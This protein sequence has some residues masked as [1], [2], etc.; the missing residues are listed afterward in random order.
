MNDLQLYFGGFRIDETIGNIEEIQPSIAD[1]AIFVIG[2][3]TRSYE[4]LDKKLVS[5]ERCIL[6]SFEGDD[7]DQSVIDEF[8]YSAK[9]LFNTVILKRLCST[10]DTEKLMT[11]TEDFASEVSKIEPL[12]CVVDY[13]SMP[14]LVTQT[15]F[16]RFMIDGCC[17]RVMWLYLTGLYDQT[18]ASKADFHQGA[19]KFFT[20]RGADGAGGISTEKIGVLALGSDRALIHSFLLENS[21]DYTF[22]LSASTD[23]SPQLMQ[24]INEQKIWL[25]SEHGV[26]PDEFVECE[27]STVIGTLKVLDGILSDYDVESGAAIDIFCSGPKSHAIAASALVS[28]RRN[29]R[30]VGRVPENYLRFDVPPSGQISI[31]TVSD[32]TNPLIAK[33]LL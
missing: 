25:Q 31:T 8:E 26:S 4:A 5:G 6:L 22:F 14:K 13:S 9:K 7:I 33:V 21:Y 20:I 2:W 24:R 11:A 19:R 30:L 23:Y 29:I 17:P 28:S 1:V 18:P 16:R 3:E 32:F 15:L 10:T 12:V 27:A